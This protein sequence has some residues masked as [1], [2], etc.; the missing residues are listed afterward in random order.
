MGTVPVPVHVPCCRR[1]IEPTPPPTPPARVAASMP[2]MPPA[3]VGRPSSTRNRF[4]SL[5]LRC[6]T[7]THDGFLVCT[8]RGCHGL[9]E[10]P[11][12]VGVLQAVPGE[13]PPAASRQDGLPGA[14]SD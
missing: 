14:P 9:H 11:E 1:W 7:Q 3:S 5:C 6:S 8:A 12:N 13:I 4:C 10:S 2:S